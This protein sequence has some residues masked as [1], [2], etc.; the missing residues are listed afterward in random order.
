MTETDSKAI[1]QDIR[2]YLAGRLVGLTRDEGLVEEVIKILFCKAEISDRGLSE[3]VMQSEPELFALYS[4]VLEASQDLIPASFSSPSEFLLDPV[5]LSYCVRSLQTVDLDTRTG[6]PF[7]E[8]Y[9]A[10]VGSAMRGQEGQFFTP[11]NAVQLL[12]EIVGLQSGD[13]VIDPAA[14]AGGFLNAAVRELLSKGAERDVVAKSVFGIEKDQLLAELAAARVSLVTRRTAEVFCGDSLALRTHEG[15]DLADLKGTFDVVLTNPPFGTKIRSVSAEDQ[16]RFQLGYKWR[17]T[18]DGFLKT[19]ALQ[20]S[21]PPQVLFIERC[22]SLARPGGRI[23][24]VV[25]ESLVS[26]SRYKYVVAFIR[27]RASVEAVIGMP[28]ALFKTSGKGGTHTKTCLLLLHRNEGT[29]TVRRRIFFA[30]AAWCGNDSRGREIPRDDLPAIGENFRSWADGALLVDSHLGHSRA[31]KD[32]VDGILAPRYY[33]PEVRSELAGLAATHDLI[34][35]G[36]LVDAGIVEIRTGDEVG[37]LAYGTGPIPFIRT[38]DLSNWELKSDPKHRVSRQIFEQLA[39]KQDVRADDIL[40]VKD[41]T[42]LIGTTALVTRYDT[43]IVYQS[44]LYKIRVL[45]R[46]RLSPYLLLAAL[47]SGPVR[48]QI[49]AKRFTQDIIDS[50]GSRIRE[51]VLPMPRDVSVRVEIQEMVEKSVNER[52]EARELARQASSMIASVAA[53]NTSD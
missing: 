37:K 28:E 26:G 51:I 9:E 8:A 16:A 36:D 10:F 42:Y 43:E 44:H 3:S 19:D 40:M 47:S 2:N 32:I 46:D 39:A 50:L 1:Y 7:G 33:D 18:D 6:D 48:R 17:R 13:R 4:R 45:D 30:E 21:V 14:G 12:V 35:I 23:G 41:G 5:S 34:S 15:G 22:L 38:S 27:D 11:Q 49:R 29:S 20:A 24:I 53:E 25:P 31:H 52:I